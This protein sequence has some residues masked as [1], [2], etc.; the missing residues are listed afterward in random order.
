MRTTIINEKITL[1]TAKLAK[2]KGF[3][4]IVE[5]GSYV[6]YLVD[7]TD[8]EYPDGG[9]AFYMKKG[10]IETED[11]YFRN[12][13]D[14][15]GD[16][17]NENYKM[18]ARPTQTVLQRWLRE[19]KKIDVLVYRNYQFL[20]KNKNEESQYY[21]DVEYATYEVALEEALIKALNLI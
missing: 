19:V 12:G 3:D 4:V 16:F 7:K 6:E 10:D 18:Y 11:G 9:G 5:T 13:S 14:E 20:I 17:S 21:D 15:W 1:P 8:P 2:E